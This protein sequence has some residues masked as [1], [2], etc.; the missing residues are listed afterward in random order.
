MS[1]PSRFTEFFGPCMWKVMHSIAYTYPE[2]P[3]MEERKTYIDFFN[4]IQNVIPCPGCGVHY[5]NYLARNP[6]KAETRNDLSKWVYD[7]HSEVNERNNKP[8]LSYEEVTKY[9][10]GF[11]EKE[12]Q[13]LNK[14]PEIEQ[15]RLMADPHFG[16]LQT[17]PKEKAQGDNEETGGETGVLFM[18][19]VV[20]AA[21][22][23]Y[24][25]YRRSKKNKQDELKNKL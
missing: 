18:S 25:V 24:V 16:L 4:T 13:A 12:N 22:V 19:L 15:R 6:I 14:L 23:A 9:Y 21:I 2:N 20:V 11:D 5:K 8:N 7:L 3:S 17:K 1:Y 10:A